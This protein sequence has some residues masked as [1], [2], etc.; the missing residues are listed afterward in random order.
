MPK[1]LS[2]LKAEALQLSPTER[3]ELIGA[4]IDSLEHQSGDSPKA[5]AAAWELEV[6]KRMADLQAGRT[7]FVPIEDALRTLHGALKTDTP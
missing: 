4:L 5:V 1:S 2:A 3:G 6:A 7:R